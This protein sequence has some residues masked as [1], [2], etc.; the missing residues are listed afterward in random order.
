MGPRVAVEGTTT[1]EVF[2]AYVEQ[3]LAPMLKER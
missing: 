3:A 1:A 2:E